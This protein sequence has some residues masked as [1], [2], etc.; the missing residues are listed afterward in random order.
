[1]VAPGPKD[2]AFGHRRF[3]CLRTV[4]PRLVPNDPTRYGRTLSETCT[5]HENQVSDSG[6]SRYGP[7][8]AQDRAFTKQAAN[9]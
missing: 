2:V 1:M 4:V 3:D 5:A 7:N 9:A 6:R 8:L